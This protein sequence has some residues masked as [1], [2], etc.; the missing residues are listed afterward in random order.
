M[1]KL[2]GILLFCTAAP[3][4]L[5]LL[6]F[7]M[8]SNAQPRNAG[9]LVVPRGY[10]S[11]DSIRFDLFGVEQGRR[12]LSPN[13]SWNNT[14]STSNAL[15]NAYSDSVQATF[16][17]LF[18]S[19]DAGSLIGGKRK[20]IYDLRPRYWVLLARCKARTFYP[21]P[22]S[23]EDFHFGNGNYW[24]YNDINF[25][26]SASWHNSTYD[27][28]DISPYAEYP[29]KDSFV[30]DTFRTR[31]YNGS[32]DTL[33]HY[34]DQ[35]RV[36]LGYSD[37]QF[38]DEILRVDSN[39]S[40]PWSRGDT[41][42]STHDS[43]MYLTDPAK[44]FSVTLDFNIDSAIDNALAGGRP[45]SL[46]P[47]ITVQVLFKEGPRFSNG[48]NGK[49]VL[50]FVPFQDSAHLSNPG[51][52]KVAE[53]VVNKHIFDSL[54]TSWKAE[55]TLQSGA[56]SHAWKFK[57]LHIMLKDVPPAMLA[58]MKAN[59]DDNDWYL[60]GQGSGS[61]ALV[62]SSHPD[63]IVAS[64]PGFALSFLKLKALLEIRV[65]STYR[66][67]V[68]VRGLDFHDTTI[69]KYLYRK[70]IAGTLDSTHSCNPNGS[71]GGFDDSLAL[72]LTHSDGAT[73]KPHEIMLNDTHPAEGG[74]VGPLSIPMLGYFDFIAG[75]QGIYSHW[76]EQDDGKNTLQYRRFRMI[77]DG[78]P[79]SMYEN[80]YTFFGGKGVNVFPR[81]YVYHTAADAYSVGWP[82]TNDM[83]ACLNITRHTA[84]DSAYW[85][86]EQQ[87]ANFRYYAEDLRGSSR[88]ALLHPNKKRFAIEAQ[89]QGWALTS[90]PVGDWNPTL[91]K[92]EAY[93]T[94]THQ[95][96][97]APDTTG[98]SGGQRPTTPE[99]INA[100]GFCM[101]AEGI[102]TFNSAQGVDFPGLK[103]G[104]PGAYGPA[105]RA[106]A[107]QQPVRLTHGYNVGHEYTTGVYYIYTYDSHGAIVD[108]LPQWTRPDSSEIS[109]D[110]PPFYLGYSNTWRAYN[111]L[112]SRMNA[113][114]DSTNGRHCLHPYKY[115]TW[116][117]AYSNSNAGNH[118]DHM[119][120]VSKALAFLKIQKTQSVL[121]WSRGTK[122]EY[123]DSAG[124]FDPDSY[125][126]VEVGMFKDSIS[127]TFINHAAIVVNT[128][129]Y[130]SL[131]DSEDLNYYNQGLDT[132]SMCHP[133]FGDIDVRKIYMTIDTSKFE[134]AFRSPYYVVRDLWHPD[135]T[136]LVKCDSAFAVY[137]K[138][139]DAK[140]L[141]FE[142]GLSIKAA[143]AS[144]I[145]DSA[146]FCFNNGHRV[147][148]RMN[149]SRDVITYTRNHHVYV[150]YPSQGLTYSKHEQSGADN[151]ATGIEVPIDTTHF[152][153][154]P[155]IMVAR[156][157]TGV[158]LVY[159]MIDSSNDKVGPTYWLRAAYQPHP[160][161]AWKIAQDVTTQFPDA[162]TL[163]DL[164][165][166][167]IA[168]ISDTTW[169]IAA[170]VN[171]TGSTGR[172]VIKGLKY[173]TPVGAASHFDLRDTT[174]VTA[175]DEGVKIYFPT[176]AS[177]PLP[178]SKYPFRLAW[179]YRNQIY[180]DRY[181]FDGAY[182]A[183]HDSTFCVSAGLNECWNA[184]PCIATNGTR[185]RYPLG[186]GGTGD[187]SNVWIDDDVAWE[188]KFQVVGAADEWMTV[189]RHRYQT[190]YISGHWGG[191]DVWVKDGTMNP[192]HWPEITAQHEQY[193]VVAPYILWADKQPLHDWI[194]ATWQADDTGG[195]WI[196]GW[197]PGTWY[198]AT[199][200]EKGRYPSL[201]LT[202]DSIPNWSK[203]S[204]VPLSI[205]FQSYLTHGGSS[206]VRITNGWVP[207]IATAHIDPTLWLF[208]PNDTNCWEVVNS[209]R[210]GHG[211]IGTTPRLFEWLP[212]DQGR[213]GQFDDD[214]PSVSRAPNEL[215][216]NIF[217][218]HSGE[219]LTLNR[220]MSIPALTTL[221]SHLATG[222]DYV[223]WLITLR[224]WADSSYI[225]TVDSFYISGTVNHSPG[226]GLPPT[227]SS[228]TLGSV[229][230]D[231]AFL[232]VELK[233]GDTTNTLRRTLLEEVS[234]S[235]NVGGSYKIAISKPK[236]Q[237]TT[238]AL[239]VHPNPFNPTA[240]IEMTSSPSLHV[241]LELYDLLGRRLQILYD[242][243][244]PQN[245]N[246]H[247][248]LDAS[249]L[250]SGAYL[251][252]ATS[253]NEV[254]STRIELV[255]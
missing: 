245:G 163:K 225:A 254:V 177:R 156:N 85:R 52:Y 113:I 195:V 164:V 55:D 154:H 239:T 119:D 66:A 138:P 252:R 127:P 212:S 178:D 60:W 82:S 223:Q 86:Y 235:L 157:D 216:T 159:W 81:E 64:A 2:L 71:I 147:A 42:T 36:I 183:R 162:S 222:S 68:R 99:E 57:Q 202:T 21:S 114:Y 80:Q 84:S 146:D 206:D 73:T 186:E 237:P 175:P 231:S 39:T 14:D 168:P 167:V 244:S 49:S 46:L 236:T 89:L 153:A 8:I 155:S 243:D 124:A 255:K 67:T 207:W 185:Y 129:M 230:D 48:F 180:Y 169:M 103:G 115:M 121:R 62:S 53:V 29:K 233:R 54:D 11:Y 176:C 238:L 17:G 10:E 200:G 94:I 199:F 242:A 193:T 126:F 104:G 166:P 125:S 250:P 24:R 248:V 87:C 15:M 59:I 4:L 135:T 228:I 181:R 128:H 150:S 152:C 83:V 149:K 174:L 50:P 31:N 221:R 23:S 95:F 28:N 34:G 100:M 112:I 196:A 189:I 118:D 141:Y 9:G 93:N 35:G 215:H 145:H 26:P 184:H 25:N 101:L 38:A 249:V 116:Q 75:K 134:A 27:T 209:T 211:Q 20:G 234:D 229:G 74:H 241:T 117:D 97:Y 182:L 106:R 192:I 105:P 6:S 77:F 122:G 224:R 227:S 61:P 205:A 247:L 44:T 208:V 110:M 201:G 130:P 107:H 140:F 143:V 204:V 210:W 22:A 188:A 240:W 132:L 96:H 218:I 70:R 32:T 217:A 47:L 151:I 246:L 56:A 40:F 90:F 78:Q 30:V 79:P 65:L 171:P 41:M 33:V 170:V 18:G 198:T 251:L 142:K 131:R 12:A 72:Y 197:I 63:S 253:G 5:L 123:L 190:D 203:D 88:V 109:G 16:E 144:E 13:Y 148:E 76:R 111:A 194:R 139:G 158:A 232:S 1:K 173:H 51:W 219:T 136:W 3:L 69:D 19:I 165:T 92:Y 120:D 187:Y 98:Y 137:I 7:P 45:D 191:F 58:Q 226:A 179:Q 161:S 160:D 220:T 37:D 43:I 91:H 108:S 172:S 214:W 133:I 102:P 213:G